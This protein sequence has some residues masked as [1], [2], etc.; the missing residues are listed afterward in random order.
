LPWH[1]DL[2][3]ILRYVDSLTN[4]INSVPAYTDMDIRFAW[5][6]T[7]NLE[8]ILVGQQLLHES[9]DEFTATW[10]PFMT[11]KIQRAVYGKVVFRF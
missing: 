2:D 5:Q 7:G 11:T 4:P 6:P 10:V 3:V 8:F 9:H 1:C